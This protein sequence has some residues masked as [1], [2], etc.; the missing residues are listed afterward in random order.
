MFNK[1]AKVTGM[2]GSETLTVT[3]RVSKQPQQVP[4][5]VPRGETAS[6]I[7]S[8]TAGSRNG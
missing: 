2:G 1:F 7:W 8:P 3:K 5:V 4:L 6:S